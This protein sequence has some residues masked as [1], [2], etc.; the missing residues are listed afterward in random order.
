MS[1]LWSR[2][3]SQVGEIER[4]SHSYSRGMGSAES[5]CWFS[6]YVLSCLILMVL[7]FYP[8]NSTFWDW[9]PFI[10]CV[11]LLISINFFSGSFL[12]ASGLPRPVSYKDIHLIPSPWLSY[13]PPIPCCQSLPMP[14]LPPGCLLLVYLSVFLSPP[15]DLSEI[16]I[17]M[18]PELANLAR[19]SSVHFYKYWSFYYIISNCHNNPS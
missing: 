17:F 4:C 2:S 1:G 9:V 13:F 12:P 14:C 7:E 15:E 3:G 8:G 10:C 6:R 18:L 5:C 19:S 16:P 11:K